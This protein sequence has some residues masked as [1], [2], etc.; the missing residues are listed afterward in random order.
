MAFLLSRPSRKRLAH[1]RKVSNSAVCILCMGQF[2]RLSCWEVPNSKSPPPSEECKALEAQL[3]LQ[4]FSSNPPLLRI[5]KARKALQE[6]LL[7][8]RETSRLW[9][10]PSERLAK[11]FAS[12]G[13]TSARNNGWQQLLTGVFATRRLHVSSARIRPTTYCDSEN[14]DNDTDLG[15]YHDLVEFHATGQLLISCALFRV[16]S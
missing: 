3:D 14:V 16:G 12:T 6:T 8:I 9:P 15:V 5:L 13:T 7:E 2:A 4:P 10:D 1:C 11:T